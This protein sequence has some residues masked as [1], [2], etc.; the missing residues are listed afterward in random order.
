MINYV[1]LGVDGC[2]KST[3]INSLKKKLSKNFNSKVTIFHLYP[4]KTSN[5]VIK[6]PHHKTTRSHLFS[7]LKLI[8]FLIIF[9]L[10]KIFIYQKNEIILFDRH[11]IDILA[12]PLR[13]RFNLNK[14]ITSQILNYFPKINII[15]FI[16]VQP[17]VAHFRKKE[18]SLGK[19]HE[20][21]QNYLALSNEY[22]IKQI[23]NEIIENAV[24]EIIK[25]INLEV[26]V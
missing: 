2:G 20:I 18:T 22:I 10:Y 5:V 6:N 15:F 1:F 26:N 17:E 9:Y 3:I 7:F 4:R 21:H 11:P 19:L 23:D 25:F 12:D 16:R 8:Y 24:D 13:Y 14:S